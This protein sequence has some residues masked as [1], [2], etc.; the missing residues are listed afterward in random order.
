MRGNS[1]LSLNFLESFRKAF[2]IE[3]LVVGIMTF[4]APNFLLPGMTPSGF[5]FVSQDVA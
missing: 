1:G 3:I 5:R 4:G 2:R